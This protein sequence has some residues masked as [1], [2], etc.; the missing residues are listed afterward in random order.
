MSPYLNELTYS[1][2]P[3]HPLCPFPS[4]RVHSMMIHDGV[5]PGLSLN[6]VA[7]ST[8]PTLFHQVST[9]WTSSCHHFWQSIWCVHSTI[10]TKRNAGFWKLCFFWGRVY[11]NESR[12]IHQ[13]SVLTFDLTQYCHIRVNNPQAPG[14][15][16]RLKFLLEKSV[17]HHTYESV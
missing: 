12:V 15:M 2:L 4:Y 6:K 9:L 14:K 16:D 8:P 1:F 5:S 10:F 17:H 13:E 7:L 3:P 11:V